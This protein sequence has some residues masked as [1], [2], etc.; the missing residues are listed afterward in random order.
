MTEKL[1]HV[2]S[3]CVI[4]GG[5]YDINKL[6]PEIILDHLGSLISD[7]KEESSEIKMH[8]CQVVPLPEP[9]EVQAKVKYNNEVLLEWG[10]KNGVNIVKTASEFTLGTGKVDE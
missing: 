3:E 2:P 4:L 7:L 1:E 5:V 8:V 9:Q 6:S 10:D